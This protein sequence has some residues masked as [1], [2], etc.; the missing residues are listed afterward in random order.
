MA[1]AEEIVQVW[2]GSRYFS[3]FSFIATV[4]DIVITIDDE[5][6]TIWNNPNSRWHSKV[7][8]V[9]NRYLTVAILTFVSYLFSGTATTLDNTVCRQFVWIY[10]TVLIFISWSSHF[11]ILIRLYRLWDRRDSVARTLTAMFTVFMS[12]T[13]IL[14]VFAA[15]Q[16]QSEYFE[17]LRTCLFLSKP[18]FLVVLLGVASAFDLVLVLFIVFNALDRPRHIDVPLVSDL[19]RD[20]AGIFMVI[21]AL[22]LASFIVSIFLD[23]S[24][25]LL[26]LTTVGALYTLINAR[27]HMRLE[28][29]SLNRGHVNGQHI[30]F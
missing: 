30:I 6:N 5:V 25:I 10:G 26:A 4:Y 20:G 9:A 22:R 23:M 2:T 24:K 3:A 21:F 16:V 29:L 19:Q 28:G 15:M 13:I 1:S 14:G 7:V 27:L 8:F 18:V 17:P 11:V 12:T